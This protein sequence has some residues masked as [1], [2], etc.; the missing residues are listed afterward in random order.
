VQQVAPGRFSCVDLHEPANARFFRLAPPATPTSAS[1]NSL[2]QLVLPNSARRNRKAIKR[3][4]RSSKAS[5][6]PKADSTGDSA[7][8]SGGFVGVV[9]HE[10]SA[11]ATVDPYMN[12]MVAGGHAFSTVVLDRLLCRAYYNNHV[13]NVLELLAAPAPTPTEEA[14]SRSGGTGRGGGGSDSGGSGEAMTYNVLSL[15]RVPDELT[16][17]MYGALF[18][19]L[20]AE[21]QLPLGLF[22]RRTDKH[23]VQVEYVMTNPARE[24]PLLEG[25][26]V[27]ALVTLSKCSL[28]PAT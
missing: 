24:T 5:H 23:G 10:Q 2:T 25:D 14:T 19:A 8:E 1:P 13:I 11:S 18:E 6:S 20:V 16:R 4:P 3:S 12:R 7:A 15:Q 26:R 21:Q 28:A 22:R 9:S 27:Y 17:G